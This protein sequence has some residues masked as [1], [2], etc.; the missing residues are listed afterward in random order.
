MVIKRETGTRKELKKKKKKDLAR[1][2]GLCQK[3]EP[4]HTHHVDVSR[5][6]GGG[7]LLRHKRTSVGKVY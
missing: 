1:S 6:G 2:V 5:G 3:H 4:Q 7:G